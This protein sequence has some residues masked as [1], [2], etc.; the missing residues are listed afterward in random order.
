M[1]GDILGD[2]QVASFYA[3][4][5]SAIITAIGFTHCVI[6]NSSPE[7]LPPAPL[8]S[9]PEISEKKTLLYAKKVK[10]N[11]PDAPA[12]DTGAQLAPPPKLAFLENV[13]AGSNGRLYLEKNEVDPDS[14]EL[15]TFLAKV[16]DAVKKTK[17][18]QTT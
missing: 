6:R 5:A 17:E 14:E 1:F 9:L 7:I 18:V 12:E 16:N 8:P 13:K 3:F 15:I 11:A 10:V 2:I 4:I